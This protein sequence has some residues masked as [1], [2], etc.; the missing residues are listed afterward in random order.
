[1]DK[2]GWVY[3]HGIPGLAKGIKDMADLK[4]EKHKHDTYAWYRPYFPFEEK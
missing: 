3:I 4:Y 2:L 1:M